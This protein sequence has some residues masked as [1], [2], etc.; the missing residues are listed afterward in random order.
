MVECKTI[1]S[2]SCVGGWRLPVPPM[3]GHDVADSTYSFVSYSYL[4]CS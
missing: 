3:E 1:C 2:Q 4:S